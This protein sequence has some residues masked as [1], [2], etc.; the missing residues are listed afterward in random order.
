[1]TI[2]APSEAFIAGQTASTGRSCGS[3]S[4]CCKL[5]QVNDSPF[6]KP[7]GKWCEHCRP[8]NGGCAIYDQRPELC[9]AWVCGWLL[10]PTVGD[11]WQPTRSKMVIN[12]EAVDQKAQQV[13]CTILVD[14][15]YA[16]R[17]AA[18]ALPQPTTRL[19]AERPA[20]CRRGHRY[21]PRDGRA[22][23]LHHSS[24]R[25][26]GSHRPPLRGGVGRAGPLARVPMG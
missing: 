19:G 18:R 17:L 20:R 13:W 21:D 16:R 26:R 4:L 15:G 22:P 9:R 10:H 12:G 1:M 23:G 11:E 7:A 14:P 24:R 8:G 3:C 5:L 2:I 25:R 6:F